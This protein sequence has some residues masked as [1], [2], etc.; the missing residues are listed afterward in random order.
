MPIQILPPRLANQIAAGE[1]V[2]RPASVVKELL[3]NSLDAGA[4]K[5]T[6]EIERGGHK[7]IRI[8]DDGCGVSKQELTLALSR[9]ATSKVSGL[10]DLEAIASLGFRGEAL[11]SISSVSRLTLT[12]RPPGQT[13]AWQA[14]AEG[15]E[16]EV[17]IQPA[18]H[19]PGT[20][21]EVRDLFFNTPARRRFLRTEKTEFQHIDDVI[22]RIAL[23]RFDIS[24]Q[25]K[26]N[27]KL[28]R[29]FR[30]GQNRAQ[31]EQRI[32][33]IFGRNFMENALHLDVQHHG[34]HL[35]GWLC[36]VGGARSQPDQQ[37]SYV[38]GRM[39][40]DK[41]LQHAVRQAYTGFLAPEQYPAYLLHMEL[42]PHEVDVNVHPAK[43]E[44]RFHQSRLVHDFVVTALLQVLSDS[45]QAESVE[46]VV[47]DKHSTSTTKGIAAP[48]YRDRVAPL[49]PSSVTEGSSR[50]SS[51]RAFR[52]SSF[53][54][55]PPANASKT[56]QE[57]MTP[58]TLSPL[59]QEQVELPVS[60]AA[61]LLA[62]YRQRYQL[63]MREQQLQLISLERL[64]SQLL[65][66]RL[67]VSA[68][69]SQNNKPLLM[70][71]RLPLQA[72]EAKTLAALIDKFVSLGIEIHQPDPH[73]A[74]I[75][76]V[77]A[78]LRHT[79][80]A[81]WFPELLDS[82][83][84]QPSWATDD[85]RQQIVNEAVKDKVYPADEIAGLI[86][87][88]DDV[89]SPTEWQACSMPAPI[90]AWIES[91]ERGNRD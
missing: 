21:L 73:K 41:V 72:N 18:S 6:I 50:A 19:P 51:E 66:R 22:R 60:S 89:F 59:E 58:L 2:E 53:T 4:T 33:G 8:R 28:I 48:A 31:E 76:K 27:N 57:L 74:I 46:H 40:R 90:D 42:D 24:L 68:L 15:R 10:D 67:K 16:M 49:P 77:P 61:S 71:I 52:S 9:H 88:A 17:K 62:L 78:L 86:R 44:V 38:N 69:D 80:I 55:K 37:Y 20:T 45:L 91:F 65:Y 79:G 36:T 30:V 85:L 1:V 47:G 35:H 29:N 84:K 43:H 70:P 11:A 26:H 64:E 56:Y 87:E 12:S 39:I 5:V 14:Y 32:A 13:E 83:G 34:M 23:S 54:G 25:L 81:D 63:V 3:E 82:L 75:R 7:L